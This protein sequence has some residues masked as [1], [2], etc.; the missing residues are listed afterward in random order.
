MHEQE[1]LALL[2]AGDERGAEALLRHYAPLMRYIIAPIVPDAQ[3][4]EECLSDAA[5]RVWEKFGTYDPARGSWTA[6]LT[7]LTRNTALNRARKKSGGSEEL[8]GDL[9]SAEPTPEER[10]LQQERRQA[11]ERALTALP[12]RDRL[13]FYR[14][15]Y[16]RQSAAP[17]L[18]PDDVARDVT[19]WRRAIGNILGGSAMCSITLNFFCLNYL[20]PTIGVILQLLGF[21]PLRRENGWFRACWLLA[22]LRAALF[23]PCI[24]LNAT[25]YS[26][27]VYASSVGTALTYGTVAA[28]LLLFF[29]F[30]R[31]L[32]AVRQKAG[33]E[34]RAGSAAALL[35]WYAAVLT[36]AYVQYNGLL[37]GLAM[38]GCYILILRSLF[39]LSREMEESGYALT[40]AP[41]RLSDEMLVRAIAALLA[42]GIACGYLF[43]GSY[44]M[45]WQPKSDSLSAEAVEIRA[46][47]LALGYPETALA[48][49]SE[50]DLLACRG[51]TLVVVHEADK[52]MNGGREVREDFGS[53][54]HISTVYDVR[55]LHFTDVAVRLPG[56]AECWR[57]LHHFRWTEEVKF[58]GTELVRLWPAYYQDDSWRP[59]GG[60]PTGR[61][62]YDDAEGNA[63]AAPCASLTVERYTVTNWL[64][65]TYH[66]EDI[67][68]EFS[69]PSRG[70]NRR[71]Y[72][73]YSTEETDG[74]TTF[75]ASRSNYTHQESR[76]QYPVQTAKDYSGWGDGPVFRR[77]QSALELSIRDDGS[78]VLLNYEP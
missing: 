46:E 52:P 67:S 18:P 1:V 56:E 48:D 4:R 61:V 50:D 74:E 34:V 53:S 21:R 55:E 44:R 2:R 12:Q 60:A 70:K 76:L 58:R 41:V 22:V 8:S 66:L 33:T 77:A 71:G 40:P 35:I 63:Y 64:G 20:L 51:A 25:I 5:L 13:L 78:V 14:K 30:W 38:L 62:L 65:W 39:R 15:Y 54:T 32:R 23:L 42:V 29:C 59:G 10:L 73:A 17:E 69:L 26:N 43:F 9:P 6:W 45:D 72:V 31:A 36:L 3:D 75:L 16:Y 7:A 24:V 68:A 19:P 28:Q 57:V 11:L 49:L 27:A 47:L 37:L